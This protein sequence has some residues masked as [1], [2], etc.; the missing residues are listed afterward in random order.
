ME[1]HFELVFGFVRPLVHVSERVLREEAVL[2]E[3]ERLA[4]GALEASPDD[5]VLVA[6]RASTYRS[7]TSSCESVGRLPVRG[8]RWL[9]SRT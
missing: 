9:R 3:K 1:E 5:R 6:V 8:S 4:L 2:T 7:G